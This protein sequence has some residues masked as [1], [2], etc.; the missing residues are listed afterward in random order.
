MTQW[1][2][3][4]TIRKVFPF[5][6]ISLCA[7]VPVSQENCG[8]K[9]QWPGSMRNY[10]V[11]FWIQQLIGK[12]TSNYGPVQEACFRLGYVLC[13]RILFSSLPSQVSCS[14]RCEWKSRKCLHGGK[15]TDHTPACRALPAQWDPQR[16]WWELSKP[17]PEITGCMVWVGFPCPV[18]HDF[19]FCCQ[20]GGQDKLQWKTAVLAMHVCMLCFRVIFLVFLRYP[21]LR[22]VSPL[23]AAHGNEVY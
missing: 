12:K 21:V 14:E 5:S 22:K 8:M 15:P 3:P 9:S 16:W 4:V 6:A 13:R 18:C 2:P 11:L 20:E 19:G 7:L 23:H 1:I 17:A 10:N